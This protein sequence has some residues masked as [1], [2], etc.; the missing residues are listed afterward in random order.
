MYNFEYIMIQ[1]KEVP[2]NNSLNTLPF[3]Q[4]SAYFTKKQVQGLIKIFSDLPE[5]P[6][7]IGQ[8]ALDVDINIRNHTVQTLEFAETTQPV[9]D[10][11]HKVVESINYHHFN[12]QLWGM[13]NLELSKYKEGNFF[14][15]H[16]DRANS[17]FRT[18]RKFVCLVG[19][20]D[21]KERKGGNIM[22]SPA[23]NSKFQTELVLERGDV[24]LMPSWV[25]YEVTPVTEGELAYI[26]TWITGP[27]FT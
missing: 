15:M 22:V 24:V 6:A 1:H 27:K 16:S 12:F 21:S 11:L 10:Q 4:W 20:S 14:V 7:L 25:P 5:K 23:G 18:E 3:F 8:A 26:N 19:L 9:F 13:E 2:F 17:P